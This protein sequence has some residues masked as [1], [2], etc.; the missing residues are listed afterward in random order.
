MSEAARVEGATDATLTRS[1][2]GSQFESPPGPDREI[3]EIREISREMAGKTGRA[4]PRRGTPRFGED[5]APAPPDDRDPP[6]RRSRHPEGSPGDH[7]ASPPA[8]RRA[9]SP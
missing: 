5:P 1:P 9:T 7:P 3:V 8:D 6:L 2:R 4:R